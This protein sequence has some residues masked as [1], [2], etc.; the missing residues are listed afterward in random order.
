MAARG[1]FGL[2]SL[3]LVAGGLL[4]ALFILLAGA[5]NGNPVNTFYFLEADTANIPGAPPVSRWTFWNICD[6]SDG[7]NTCSG[8]GFGSISPAR[9]FDPPS[10]R[11]FGTTQNVPSQFVGTRYYFYLSRFMFAFALIALFFG[12][13]ALFTGLLALCTRLGSYLS[14]LLTTLAFIFQALTAALMTA[15]YVKGRD[16]FRQN[17]QNA[18]IGRYAFGFEWAAFACWFLATVL[19]CVGGSAAKKDNYGS[20]KSRG[21]FFKGRRSAST[22]SRGSFIKADKEYS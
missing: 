3:I 16:H 19:F 20:G 11:N 6:G 8:T 2:V 21:G 4:L 1:L 17:N 15:A 5:I 14:G 18:S 9:P 7:T 13:C 22:R 10:G 12:A